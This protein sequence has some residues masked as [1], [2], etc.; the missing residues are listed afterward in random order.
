[1]KA[2]RGTVSLLI[3][4]SLAAVTAFAAA[5]VMFLSRSAERVLRYEKGLNS[6]YAAESGANWALGSLKAGVRGDR[7]ASF[8]VGDCRVKVDVTDSDEDGGEG[9]IGSV[10]SDASGEFQRYV[11]ITYTREDGRLKVTDVYAE[12]P[13]R[14]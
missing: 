1:M 2:R 11:R 8:S 13:R 6:A 10:G 7:S 5:A 4:L 3:L 12:D 14:F 9:V